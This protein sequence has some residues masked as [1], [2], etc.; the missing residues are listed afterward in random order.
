MSVPLELHVIAPRLVTWFS[1]NGWLFQ[2][3]PDSDQAS[4][5]VQ[6]VPP[7]PP[8]LQDSRRRAGNTGPLKP[9]TENLRKLR[10]MVGL[11]STLTLVLMPKLAD[12]VPLST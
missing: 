12:G 4:A 11:L 3:N 10:W 9:W 6:T 1:S 2:F 8:F 5:A 7:G